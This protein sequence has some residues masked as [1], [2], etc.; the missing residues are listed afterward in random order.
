MN[1][2]PQTPALSLGP[3]LFHWPAQ[4][5]RDFYF[6]VADEAP[7]DTVYL[8][9]VICSKRMPFFAPYLDEV[10][11]RLQRS[12]KRIRLSTLAEITI[13]R[14][15][16]EV[17][18]ACE[19]RDVIVEANDASALNRLA[20]RPHT[21]GPYLNVYN[22]DTLAFLVGKGAIHVTLPS[23]IPAD[24]IAIL[25]ASARSLGIGLEVQVYGRAPLALSARCY[26]ARAHGRVKDT[27]QFV[28]E[29][30][31]DGLDLETLDAKSFL[32][33]N[34]IQVL[35]HTCLNLVHALEAMAAQGVTHFRISPHSQDMV[36]V[37]RTF[38]SVLDR[39]IDP[40]EASRRLQDIGLPVPFSNGFYQHVE[41]YRW[42]N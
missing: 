25:G 16:R 31:A 13:Q 38:R 34:G 42:A 24:A 2:P 14:D 17:E 27:C 40:D 20:G 21:I 30:D 5:K 28:C 12:G 33:V 11:E 1:R 36:A 3:I 29:N 22:E 23:E 10:I 6:R 37:A 41:G 32:T 15:Q 9:E 19:R 4:R 39:E 35:S 8:G 26:H 7:V 18:L